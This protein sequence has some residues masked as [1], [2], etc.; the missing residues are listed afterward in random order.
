MIA[1][2]RK[3][4]TDFLAGTGEMGGRIRDF[5]W[6]STPLGSIESWPDSLRTSVSLILSSRHPMWIGWGREMTFLYNEAYLHVLGPAKHPRALGRPASEVW[7]EIWDVC[8]PLADKVFEK[9]EAT[10]ADDVR[11]F[12]NRGDFIEETFYSFSYSPIRDDSGK[13]CG[14]F[15]PSTDVTPKVLNAR[16]LSTLSELAADAPIEKTTGGACSFAARILARNPDDIPFALLYLADADGRRAS[17]AQAIGAF[18][19]DFANVPS[20]D[21]EAGAAWSP[22]SIGQ[23]FRS[24]HRATVTI[25]NLDG[26]P[27]GVADQA[28]KQAVVLPVA[29]RGEHQPYGVLVAGVNPCRPLHVDHLTFFELIATQVATAIQNARAVEE[30]KKRA[31]MLAEIDRAKTVFFS[32]VSHEFRTPLTLMLGPL[33]NLLAKSAT[34]R[35]E[36][37]EQVVIAHRNSLRLLKLVNSLLDF[38][39]LEAGRLKA[40]YTPTELSSLT[41]ELASNFRSAMQAA[42]LQ[43]DVDCPPLAEPVYVDREMWERIVLNL[44]S[45]AF[46]FTFEGRVA[47]RLRRSGNQAVLTVEDTGI[48]I[49]EGELPRIFERFYRV[50]GAKGR[51][52]EGTGIGLALIR[53]YVKLHGGSIEAASRSGEGSTFTITVPFGS[54]HLSRESIVDAGQAPPPATARSE[55]FMAEVAT[56][57]PRNGDAVPEATGRIQA[58]RPAGRRQRRHA[59]P[60]H[61]HSQSGFRGDR[62]ERREGGRG[63]DPRESSRSVDQRRHDAGVRRLRSP[64][65]RARR[66]AHA[67]A[68]RHSPLGARRRGDARRRPG[69]RRRRLSGEA[70]YRERASRARGYAS[71][72]GERT[73][74]GHGTR[75]GASRRGRDGSRSGGLDSRKHHRWLCGARSRLAPDLCERR[76]RAAHGDA[77]RGDARPEALGPLSGGGRHYRSKGIYEDGG[78]TRTS[79]IRKSLRTLEPLVPR[80]DVSGG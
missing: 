24:A 72:N 79:R 66:R 38:S 15:C 50:E 34:L 61:A 26:L 55:A 49:P 37:H 47:V 22:W 6:A 56:W 51:T 63:R 8:G 80:Q 65:R 36:E 58:A 28:V 30:E 70:I 5:D 59:R 3:N 75:G 14:L 78:R 7:D 68:S 4:R 18:A 64:S 74:A 57:L 25:E 77:P 43:L 48:G 60:R 31:D 2:G 40:S 9:G 54:S 76:N 35:T 62:R 12:M 20:I 21:L 52:Y 32:N 11:L 10:F 45:N 39:R 1:A 16:R 46:K 69:S 27:L 23:V 19:A 42:G 41:T 17:L 73:A 67:Y 13:V 29:S 44:L 71:A 33:E 53:E